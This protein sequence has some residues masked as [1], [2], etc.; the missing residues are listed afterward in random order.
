MDGLLSFCCKEV[1]VIKYYR[2]CVI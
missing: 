2:K 1:K